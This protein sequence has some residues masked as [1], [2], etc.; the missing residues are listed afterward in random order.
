MLK[1]RPTKLN[2]GLNCEKREKK[3][4]EENNIER[5]TKFNK[6]IL[7]S[8]SETRNEMLKKYF[9]NVLRTSHKI[10][11]EEFKINKKPPEDIVLKIAKEKA[12]SVVEDFQEEMI[13]ASDQ[14]LVCENKIW[15]KPKTLEAARKKL[16]FLKNKTHK[17]YSSI[18][19]VYKQKFYFQKVKV[20]SL[21][22]ANLTQDKIE[23]YI[24]ANKKT[25]LTTVGSY[26]I[27]EN[28]KYKFISIIKGDVETILGFPIKD[29][30]EKIKNE[31]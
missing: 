19:V 4:G 11:E 27:E 25:V 31:E 26:K 21:F 29:L 20:A 2:C 14:I 5:S 23:S 24:I 13:I 18:Y 15:S 8:R 1:K 22:F 7:A 12:L 9:A 10:D 3:M 16:L 6:V 30:I 28:A 17:L